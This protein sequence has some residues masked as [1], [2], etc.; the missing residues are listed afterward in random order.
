MLRRISHDEFKSD[1]LPAILKS[2]LRNPEIIMETIGHILAGLTIDMSQY[3]QEV[4]TTETM[5]ISWLWKH[6]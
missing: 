2:M 6:Y 5:V 1:L 4:N 3:A